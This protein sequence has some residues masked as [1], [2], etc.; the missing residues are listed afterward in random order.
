MNNFSPAKTK[1]KV[2]KSRGI[3]GNAYV[4]LL[5]DHCELLRSAYESFLIWEAFGDLLRG[6]HRGDAEYPRIRFFTRLVYP[7]VSS[8]FD[9]FVINLY[10]FYDHR[11]DE[12]KTLVDVG[13]RRGRI[14][15]PLEKRIRAK[16]EEA[17][18]FAVRTNIHVLRN[19]HVGH[20]NSLIRKRSSL[21]TIHPTPKEL[22]DY[23][24]R[25]AEVLQLCVR[26]AP[27]SHS[28]PRYNVFER[29]IVAQTRMVIQYLSG[30]KAP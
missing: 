9:S 19:Q 30:S 29:D 11:S 20:Y 8:A 4:V 26:D 3:A 21:T 17:S 18:V 16:I 23:F 5:Q 6:T 28:P 24:A 15:Q 7:L 13:I 25:L 12:L 22:R 27:L 2:P 10:K 1:S 14:S